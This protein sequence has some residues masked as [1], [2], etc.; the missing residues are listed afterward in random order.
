M[1]RQPFGVVGAVAAMLALGAAP[2]FATPYDSV[3]VFGDSNVDNG[4]L[5]ALGASLGVAINPPP[6]YG[7][8]NNN[9]PVVV[10]YLASDL[11]VPLH[12]YAYS[13]AATGSGVA[14]GLIPNTLTQIDAYLNANGGKADPNALYVYWAGSNDL[15]D[16]LTNQPLPAAS[17]PGAISTALGNIDTGLEELSVAG[18]T[19]IVVANRTPRND[20]T[21]QDNRNGITFNAALAADLS[22]LDVAAKLV[23]FDDYSLVADM[24]TEPGKYGFVH[25]Q[26]T[27]TCIDIPACAGNLAVASHYVFWD[28]AH[29]TTRVH[30][31]MADAIVRDVPEPASIALALP[32][33]LGL[34][35]AR[36]RRGVAHP[37]R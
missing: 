37:V 28:D 13:G 31:L 1:P 6:N 34:V 30:E 10:E 14:F 19:G 9:G 7:G 12:D 27:D 17:I 36:R 4:N 8:R 18:A 33:I 16:L 11:G 21:S 23:A 3:V 29:K 5:A 2:A 15:L 32:A 35:L 26:P 20:L 25:T 24:I 22:T